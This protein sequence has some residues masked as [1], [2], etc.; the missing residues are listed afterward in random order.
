MD[1]K[2]KLTQKERDTSFILFCRPGNRVR[3]RSFGDGIIRSYRKED[4]MLLVSL[5]FGRPPAKLWILADTLVQYIL[6]KDVFLFFLCNKVNKCF[7][8]GR[9]LKAGREKQLSTF[10]CTQRT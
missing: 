2:V 8:F 7:S 3:I 10:S 6:E 5:P 1:R 9:C 4:N